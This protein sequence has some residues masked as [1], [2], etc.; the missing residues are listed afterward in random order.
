MLQGFYWNSYAETRWIKLTSQADQLA[1]Y[2]DLI[3]L[4][5]SGYCSQSDNMGY[6]PL[7][8]WN[9]DSSFGTEAE[10]RTMISTFK[11]KG[12]GTIADVVVNHHNTLGWF[13]FPAE[14]YKGET[15]Q[16]TSADICANDDGGATNAEAQKQGVSLSANNDTGTDWAGCRDLDHKSANV[17]RIVKAYEDFLLNDLGYAGFRYDMVIGFGAEYLADYNMTSKPKFSVGEYWESTTRIKK[18]IDGTKVEGAPTSAAFDFQFRYRVRDA[19]N[20]KDV[21]NLKSGATDEGGAPLIY[22]KDYQRYAITFVENHDTQYR[23]E[24][25]PLDPLKTDIAAANAFMLSMPGTPCVFLAHWLSHKAD[26]RRQIALRK[27]VG[28]TNQSDFSNIYGSSAG[29]LANKV[30]GQ[31]GSLIVAVG[32]G[33]VN[34]YKPTGY[35]DKFTCVLSGTNYALWISNEL[36]ADWNATL[37]LIEAEEHAEAEEASK[38]TPYDATIYVK[39]D[40]APVYFYVWDS[41]DNTQLNGNWPGVQ[42]AT[43]TINGETW[44]CQT[45]AINAKDYYFNIIFNQGE[46]LPQT[47]NIT[48]LNSTKYYTATILDGQMQY[49][50]VTEEMLPASIEILSQ[51]CSANTMYDLLGRRVTAP[52]KGNIYII[53]KKKYRF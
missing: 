49:K 2:F 14:T 23:S 34:R 10:L 39:A 38:F 18:W 31:K 32:T 46:G 11:Q 7:Y 51:P 48:Y 6:M 22:S 35:T 28:I 42:P 47:S 9:Q 29:M 16:L 40:F 53:N 30:E 3:W 20:G 17:N 52:R 36:V 24:N 8:Y 26:I 50:D 45:F 19:F 27:L 4:P 41:N 1:E 33:G 37:A 25:E 15:Y 5:N 44:Y 12:L 43:T 21:R 13:D